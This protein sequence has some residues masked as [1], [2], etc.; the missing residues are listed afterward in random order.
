MMSVNQFPIDYHLGCFWFVIA[1]KNASMNS[2]EH[3]S[4][5]ICMSIIEDK[6][7]E[8]NSWVKEYVYL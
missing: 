4:F 7:S 8:L 2:F 3:V 5:D 6:Y 1:D